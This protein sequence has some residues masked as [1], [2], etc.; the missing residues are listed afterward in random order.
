MPGQMQRMDVA[1]AEFSFGD[2][3]VGIVQMATYLTGVAP[4]YGVEGFGIWSV[5]GV[6]GLVAPRDRAIETGQ[7]LIHMLQSRKVNPDWSRA[8]VEMVAQI[9]TIS[10]QAANDV[11][12]RIASR[13]PAS[14][15]RARHRGRCRMTSAGNGRTARWTRRT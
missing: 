15:A 7:A 8:N 13:Y 12:A 11:S 2:D 10:Q 4:Q 6:A 5:A 14:P 9:N 1:P 3:M